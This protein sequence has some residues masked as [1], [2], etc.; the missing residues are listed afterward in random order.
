MPTQRLIVYCDGSVT[1]TCGKWRSR[2][3]EIVSLFQSHHSSVKSNYAL[4]KT[5]SER[6]WKAGIIVPKWA[7]KSR[8]EVRLVFTSPHLGSLWY[9]SLSHRH[10]SYRQIHSGCHN[11][12]SLFFWVF[13]FSFPLPHPFFSHLCAILFHLQILR[14]MKRLL[15]LMF[16][17]C[18]AIFDDPFK[19]CGND[20]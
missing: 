5:V 3:Q 13:F 20:Y 15:V 14:L 19:A 7:S 17:Y 9:G 11:I 6:S 2:E 4:S 12:C 16:S 10:K 18:C 8:V 1:A